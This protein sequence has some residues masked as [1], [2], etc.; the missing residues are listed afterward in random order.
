MSELEKL[1]QYLRANGIPYDRIDEEEFPKGERL[2]EKM[3]RHQ[4]LI[5]NKEKWKWSIIC[6]KG[7][8]GYKDG[9][10]EVY[11][12]KKVWGWLTAEEV[13]ERMNR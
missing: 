11:N 5:P 9:L 6:Q 7:S 12:G 10:L 13:I 2:I 1:E 8:Y 3:D 4:I